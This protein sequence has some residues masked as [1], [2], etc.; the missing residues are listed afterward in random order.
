MKRPRLTK[1]LLLFAF[2]LTVLLTERLWNVS[3]YLNP[4]NIRRLLDTGGVYAPLIYIGMMVLVAMSPFPNMPMDIAAGAFFGP[5]WGAVYSLTGTL[6]GAVT[7][8]TISRLLGRELIERYLGG[9]FNFC[10]ACSDR[11]LTKVVFLSRLLPIFSIDIVSYGAGLTKMSLKRFALATFFGMMP[12]A[13][14]YNYFGSLLFVRK[15]VTVALGLVVVALF[16]II[17]RWIERK[18]IFSMR[19]MFEHLDKRPE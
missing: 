17:P 7:G 9:H 5:F 14:V 6:I 16:F 2:I 13:F 3:S 15:G 8:F 18:N 10:T 1:A 19:K 4:E 12:L 11:L